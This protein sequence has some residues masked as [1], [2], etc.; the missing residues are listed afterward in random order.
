V[1]RNQVILAAYGHSMPR[2]LRLIT[3]EALNLVRSAERAVLVFRN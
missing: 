2:L 3:D 1:I